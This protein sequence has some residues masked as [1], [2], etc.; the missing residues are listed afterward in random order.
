MEAVS[1]ILDT[2][3]SLNMSRN[4]FRRDDDKEYIDYSS[5]TK[6]DPS[7]ELQSPLSM[8]GAPAIELTFYVDLLMKLSPWMEKVIDQVEGDISVKPL[9]GFDQSELRLPPIR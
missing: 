7:E 8:I 3:C 5:I 2:V 4:K 6:E 1:N 9:N